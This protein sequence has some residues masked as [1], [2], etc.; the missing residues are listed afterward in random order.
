MTENASLQS[1]GTP[2]E[3]AA[4]TRRLLTDSPLTELVGF[5]KDLHVHPELSGQEVRTSELVADHL[6]A[7]GAEVTTRVGGTGVVGL[8]SNGPGP[9][10][11]VRADMDALPVAEKTGFDYASTV[12]ALGPDGRPTP[13][14]HACGHDVHVTALVGMVDALARGKDQ[15][16]GTLMAIAQPAEETAEGAEAM[17]R[18]G[19]FRRFGKPDVALAQHVEALG[20][21]HVAHAPGLMASAALNVDVDIHGRGG[22][23]AT[24][25]V[26]VD[27]IVV[28]SAVVLRLQT[29]VSR[30]LP[31]GEPAVVSIGAFHSGA[32]ANVIPDDAHLALNLRFQSEATR[33]K[34]LE[35][36]QRITRA[37]C[38]AARCPREP[39]MRTSCYFP[40][41]VNDE[42]V[43]S[44][45]R[46]VHEELF[47]TSNV[48][49][50]PVAMG[51][52]DFSAFGVADPV[53]HYD[54]PAIPYCYWNFGGYP[55]Q[56]WEDAPG[57]TYWAKVTSLPGAHTGSF[58]P[59]PEG[60]I[61]TGLYALTGAALAFFRPG[62]S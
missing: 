20:V 55:T 52:E 37:E 13:V 41:T 54:G 32:K 12:V 14:M 61:V 9:F 21:G 31:P 18:D 39:E 29:I 8:L 24:P 30:E 49:D 3:V 5:Y 2:S 33:D 28:A 22:H 42:A 57:T 15:W 1:G 43:T 46:A 44:V 53:H 27:P 40:V 4:R 59:E 56:V 10:V 36:I 23:A 58:A 47:G 48:H 6:R 34:L 35:A 11:M 25:E 45:T 16:H 62:T 50:L 17:L 19:I 26:C 7:A 38:E 60:A 51:S